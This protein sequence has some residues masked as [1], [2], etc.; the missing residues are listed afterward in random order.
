MRSYNY[1]ELLGSKYNTTVL[2]SQVENIKLGTVKLDRELKPIAAIKSAS[3]HVVYF[4]FQ[5]D[6][7]TI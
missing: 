3:Q 5:L 1:R 2:L 6:I 7:I 4:T